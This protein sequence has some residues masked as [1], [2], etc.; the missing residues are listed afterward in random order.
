MGVWLEKVDENLV[1]AEWS[2]EETRSLRRG[3]SAE[4]PFLHFICT[5]QLQRVPCTGRAQPWVRDEG[6]GGAD[7]LRETDAQ[8]PGC[9]FPSSI[10]SLPLA[11]GYLQSGRSSQEVC[12]SEARA[13]S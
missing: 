2:S 5:G 1:P 9:S 7:E 3:R 10:S 8:S 4:W 13:L 11:G 12:S 6:L